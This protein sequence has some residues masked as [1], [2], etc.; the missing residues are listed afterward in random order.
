M[1][2]FQ[3]VLNRPDPPIVF[4]GATP[5][6]DHQINT[7][8]PTKDEIKKAIKAMKSG[9]APGIDNINAELLKVDI[10]TSAT[11]LTDLFT[12]MWQNDKI[13]ADWLKGLIVKLPK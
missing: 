12:K 4:E 11:V 3:E 5:V 7:D 9:K 13:P 6:T 8:P 1:E 10:E 2:H